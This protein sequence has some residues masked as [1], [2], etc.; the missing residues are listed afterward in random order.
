MTGQGDCVGQYDVGI[1]NCKQSMSAHIF[2]SIFMRPAQ[3]AWR[4]LSNAQNIL[5][6]FQI[7][8]VILMLQISCWILMK[9][10]W[11]FCTDSCWA[12]FTL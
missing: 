11:K 3:W 2:I 8:V 9:W 10:V 12:S 5:D 6:Y 7:F 1:S 4:E